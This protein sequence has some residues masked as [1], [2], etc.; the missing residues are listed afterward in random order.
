MEALQALRDLSAYHGIEFASQQ[1]NDYLWFFDGRF[2]AIDEIV[3]RWKYNN[4]PPSRFP[5]IA[6][7]VKIADE[8]SVR[9]WEE[10][11]KREPTFKEFAERTSSRNE[12][13]SVVLHEMVKRLGGPRAQ[14]SGWLRSL[15]GLMPGC[16]FHE[17]AAKLEKFWSEEA[18]RLEKTAWVVARMEAMRA[19]RG[20]YVK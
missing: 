5:S 14:Y 11:K 8:I 16:G 3:Q 7:L 4:A 17:D 18:G 19:E 10:Q 15:E 6:Q 12:Q 20:V 1:L 9:K 13:G 2:D